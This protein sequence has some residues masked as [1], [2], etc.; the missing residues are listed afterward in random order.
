MKDE[1]ELE[2]MRR[3]VAATAAGFATVRGLIAPA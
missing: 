2:R 1:V 3:A